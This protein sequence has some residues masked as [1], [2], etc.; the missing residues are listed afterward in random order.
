M[1]AKVKNYKN[2][3]FRRLKNRFEKKVLVYFFGRRR[4]LFDAIK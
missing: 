1:L 3:F 2:E 4:K